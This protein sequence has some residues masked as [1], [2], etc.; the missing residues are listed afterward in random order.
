MDKL[1]GLF[2]MK[3]GIVSDSHD[4]I[5]GLNKAIEVLKQEKIDLTI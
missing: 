2:K 3:V 4:N 1:L 5:A